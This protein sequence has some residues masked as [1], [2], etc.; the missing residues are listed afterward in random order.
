MRLGEVGGC[1]ARLGEVGV[2][3]ARLGEVAGGP[4]RLG[5]VE[6]CPAMLGEGVQNTPKIDIDIVSLWA[7]PAKVDGDGKANVR[8]SVPNYNG[9]LR[10]IAVA[11]NDDKTGGYESFVRRLK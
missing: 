9:K 5:E 6:G 11:W 4:A 3:S 10:L 2:V 7:L 8:L 1:P